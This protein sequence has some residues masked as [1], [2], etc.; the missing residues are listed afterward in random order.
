M[1]K[2]IRKLLAQEPR[3]QS[4]GVQFGE[5]IAGVY[6]TGEV[7]AFCAEIIE[8]AA[9]ECSDS[10]G[11]LSVQLQ[12]VSELLWSS[13]INIYK[14]K[15]LHGEL[16]KLVFEEAISVVK[17]VNAGSVDRHFQ[18]SKDAMNHQAKSIITT[19]TSLR[20]KASEPVSTK[21]QHHRNYSPK[22]EKP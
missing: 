9:S 7:A 13:R 2:T 11:L 21:F 4:G 12:T 16:T 19:L 10:T 17:S 1:T 3:V 15:S 5:D 8:R 22:K 18:D 20:D 14:A 6:F